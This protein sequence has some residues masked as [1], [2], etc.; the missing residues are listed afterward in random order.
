MFAIF[1]MGEVLPESNSKP[2][3]MKV[4]HKPPAWSFCSRTSTFLPSL[5]KTAAAVKPPTPLPIT[6]AS[7]FCGTSYLSNS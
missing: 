7:S 4:W 6:M 3:F 1:K 5:A 2:S